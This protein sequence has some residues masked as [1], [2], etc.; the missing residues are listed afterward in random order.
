MK[1]WILLLLI[2]TNSAHAIE[3]ATPRPKIG[4]VLS[5]GG[6]RGAAHIGV[7]EALEEMNVPIDFIVG[8]SMGAVIGGL[9]ASGVPIQQLKQDFST[10]EWDEIFSYNINRTDLY[11]RRKLDTDI[12]VIKNFVSY[13]NGKI[14]I[15]YGIITGQSL[16]EVFNAYLL[17]IQP[18]KDFDHLNIPFKAVATDLVTG[19]AI[20]L[21]HGDM[22]LSLLASM[23]VPGIICP[24][25]K[26]GYMLVD[27]GVS[28]NVPIETA[29]SMGADVLIVVDVSTPM[30]TK[31]QIV[32]LAGVIDQ[33]S[34]ILTFRNVEKSKALLDKD[35]VLITPTLI[36]IGTSDFQ[37]FSE[38]VEPGKVAALHH[39]A[40]LRELAHY[41]KTHLP[42]NSPLLSR[43]PSITIDAVAVK[44]PV[45]LEPETYLDYIHFDEALVSPITINNE[46]NKLYGLTIFDRIDYGMQEINGEKVL[47]IEPVMDVS[48]P[49]YIQ[50]S[51]LLDT[52][53][54]LTNTFG[55]VL[56]ITNPRANSYLGEWRLLGQIGQGESLLAEFYQPLTRDLAWFVNPRVQI[57]RTPVLYYY[58]FDAIGDLVIT[59]NKAAIG[60]GR[61][62]GNWGRL[63]GYWQ[64]TYSDVKQETGWPFVSNQY[65]NN[66]EAGVLFEWDTLD[67]LYFPKHG[68]KGRLIISKFAEAF[69]GESD[70]SQFT[71][72]NIAAVGSGKHSLALGTLYNK[73]LQNVP[74]YPAQFSLGGLFE[75]TGFANNELVGDNSALVTAIYFYEIKQL[76]IIPNRPALC[77]VGTSLETGKTWGNANQ[78]H[79]R[80]L[81]SGSIFVASD[82]ILGPIYL[83][84]GLTDNGH[85]A[86]HLTLRPAF[87]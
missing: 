3:E 2:L 45:V 13:S 33:L 35:D 40:R 34:N 17:P 80:W 44:N 52:D 82:T 25:D 54:H 37:K 28:A 38:A 59:Q 47:V 79:D 84:F 39:G 46:I 70:F 36:N 85:R 61:N 69:G 9:Y 81:G 56:G 53:F 43:L 5:G 50:A 4:L 12:F 72:K 87:K 23:A 68:V 67:N 7:I 21:D 64:Y 31:T 76:E 26:N 63:S 14:H 1:K 29:Q 86:A 42:E 19:K 11:Y 66:G 74:N 6:A 58:D 10:L 62:F 78:S 30:S 57:Q 20:V 18:I 32:D 75:L 16:Y 48:D 8:T 41:R 55:F 51:L 24:V 15:P 73:T 65:V 77:Y 22:A 27:G 60:M 49:I 83:A 71:A